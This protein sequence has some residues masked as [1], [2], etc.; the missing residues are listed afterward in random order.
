MQLYPDASLTKSVSEEHTEREFGDNLL[1]IKANN[2]RNSIERDSDDQ[3]FHIEDNKNIS[4]VKCKK[5]QKV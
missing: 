1:S 5:E 2:N 3:E 4:E